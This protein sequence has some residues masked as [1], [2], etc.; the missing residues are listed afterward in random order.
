[1]AA[2]PD[3]TGLPHGTFLVIGGKKDE[4]AKL[5][6]ATRRWN[7]RIKKMA[8]TPGVVIDEFVFI[9]SLKIAGEE[10]KVAKYLSEIGYNYDPNDAIRS[11]DDPRFENLL[12][13]VDRTRVPKEKPDIEL[14]DLEHILKSLAVDRK[15]EKETTK[16][17]PTG[18]SP[19]HTG[20]KTPRGPRLSLSEKL[21]KVVSQG[22]DIVNVLDVSKLDPQVD[23]TGKSGASIRKRPTTSRGNT[24]SSHSYP[25]I[26]S[27]NLRGLTFALDLLGFNP[28]DKN[29]IV[30]E[31]TE[32]NAAGVARKTP[33]AGKSSMTSPAARISPRVSP[34]TS[35]SVRTVGVAGPAGPTVQ[36]SR[37]PS[38]TPTVNIPPPRIMQ[39][40]T[41]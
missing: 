4:V 14:K 16:T 8:E 25:Y 35:P 11:K 26:I 5:T 34:R 7:N 24:Y 22:S 23:P 31:W 40:G 6:G 21:E 29:T 1:M 17:T 39:R 19:V 15:I 27:S 12:T 13:G 20:V 9:P 18:K 30:R 2:L 36:P 28:E 3:T 10:N 33:K 41:Q 32:A 38:I 37:L